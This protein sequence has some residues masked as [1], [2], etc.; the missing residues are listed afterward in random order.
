MDL[1]IVN[2]LSLSEAGV[3][4]DKDKELVSDS[5]SGTEMRI[6]QDKTLLIRIFRTSC[7]R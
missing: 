4:L 2:M 3:D 1:C 7:R 5:I 6:V